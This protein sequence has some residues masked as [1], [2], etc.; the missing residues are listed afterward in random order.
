MIFDQK[1]ANKNVLNLKIHDHACLIYEN[2]KEWQKIIIPFLLAG[3]QQGEKCVY[4]VNRRTKDEIRHYLKEEG[5]DVNGK[6]ISGQL[7]ILDLDNLPLNNNKHDVQQIYQYCVD[8]IEKSIAEG[9]TL[10]RLSCED[11]FSFTKFDSAASIVK[12]NS[13]LNCE[14]FSRYP[15]ITLAQ[16]NRRETMP[17]LLRY[18]IMSHPILINDGRIFKNFFSVLNDRYFNSNHNEWEID[19]WL[20]NIEQQSRN[21][22]RVQL[23]NEILENSTQPVLVINSGG[24]VVAFNQALCELLGFSDKQIYRME[25]E[26]LSFLLDIPV[27]I[28][29]KPVKLEREFVRPDG[30]SIWVEMSIS[31]ALNLADD[32]EYYCYFI[33]DI[34]ERKRTEEM[35]KKSEEKYRLMAENA[36][37]MIAIIDTENLE[38][39][40]VSPSNLKLLGY[41]NEELMGKS[42]LEVVHIEDREY[43]LRVLREGIKK[44]EGS[45]QYR[46]RRKDGSYLWVESL[47]KVIKKSEGNDEVL[48]VTRDINKRKQAEEALRYSEERYRLIADNAYDGISVVSADYLTNIYANPALLKMLGYSSDDLIGTKVFDLIHPEDR[49][50]VY[51]AV[52]AGLKSGEGTVQFRFRR[53]DSSYIWLEA[54]GKFITNY[55]T[56]EREILVI[57]RDITQR[58]DIEEALRASELRLKKITENM[59]DCIAFMNREGILEYVSSSLKN[60]LGYESGRFLGKRNLKIIHSEDRHRIVEFVLQLITNCSSGSIQYRALHAGGYYVWLESIGN[61]LVDNKGQFREIVFATR[62]ITARK[63]VE[64]RLKDQVE[65]HRSLIDNMNEL[66]YTYDREYKFTFGNKKALETTGYTIEERIGT[67]LL[68]VIPERD[69]SYVQKQADKR[70]FDG[71]PGSYEHTI[72]CKDGKEI[73]VR[74]KS[75]SI[76]VNGEITGGL[77]LAE[78]ITDQRKM[79]KEMARLAQLH[80]VGEMAAGMGHEIRNPMTTVKGFLQILRQDEELK[81]YQQNIDIMLEELERANE[82]ISEFLSLAKNKIVNL[83]LMNINSIINALFPLLQADAIVA[84]KSVCLDLKE[85]PDLMLDEKEIRQLILN[86]VRNGL[87]ATPVHG[88]IYIRTYSKANQVIMTV[89]DSGNGIDPKVMDK[90]GTPF[91]TTKEEGTGLGLAVC[92]SIIE[93]HN[94]SVNIDSGKY[95][96]IFTVK[97]N[98]P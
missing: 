39:N 72:R 71:I 93:R 3:L 13:K 85:I 8:F 29:N 9:Y 20:N 81:K 24:S 94:A 31:A 38:F 62:D 87:E 61:T 86:L 58:K 77:V 84:D 51:D 7:V 22:G 27:E 92:Y 64:Q 48:L 79:E 32:V 34:S 82:I 28:S 91:F 69:R 30:R 45:G 4:L 65:H 57:S 50:Y 73:L 1:I 89:E 37:D 63:V 17:E 26:K 59:L 33:I 21:K 12:L 52:E 70:L 43:V 60:I 95:G 41:T 40:Y 5:V 68:E 49:D 11:V 76:K 15:C 54:T 80:I 47:G 44:G 53:A 46:D 35:L 98:L 16:Y 25:R 88:E 23:L 18:A 67:S 14:Y 83:Q 74:V 6:E 78:D 97:F 90:L 96:T 75:S 42:C 56:K 55:N 10:V 2:D 19:Y 36:T 66:L